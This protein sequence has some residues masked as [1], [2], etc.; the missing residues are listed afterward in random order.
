V[1]IRGAVSNRERDE[2]DPP[3][4]LDEVLLLE[5]LQYSGQLAVRIEL[6]PGSELPVEAFE[7]AREVLA[8][9]PGAAPV[10]VTLGS[11]N[12]VQAPRFRSRTLRVNPTREALHSLQELFGK[13][14]VRLVRERVWGAGEQPQPRN[15]RAFAQSHSG[16]GGLH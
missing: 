12:G 6:E 4:F 3:I 13:T 1:L 16:G 11:D 9:H 5:E 15:R 10:D 7:K 8:A 2:E 14:R